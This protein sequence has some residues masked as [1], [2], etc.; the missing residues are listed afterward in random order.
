MASVLAKKS[1]IHRREER[2]SVPGFR[3]EH[4]EIK[5]NKNIVPMLP[6]HEQVTQSCE[7]GV[8]DKLEPKKIVRSAILL[9]ILNQE[10]IVRDSE[11]LLHFGAL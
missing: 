3:P 10:E 11:C 1:L 4:K 8:A 7:D 2:A 9:Q 5:P 6:N